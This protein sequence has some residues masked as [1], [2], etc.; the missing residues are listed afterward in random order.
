MA[1]H[2]V[3]ITVRVQPRAGRNQVYLP[4]HAEQVQVRVTAPAAEDQANRA[5]AELLAD[6]LGVAKSRVRLVIGH[7]R[8]EKT[9]EIDGMTEDQ[10]AARVAALREDTA[11]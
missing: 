1:E 11:G 8:R 3:A 10:L 5:A 7:K 4:N 6:W 9:F 2:G